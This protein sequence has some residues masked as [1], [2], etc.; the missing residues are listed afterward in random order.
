MGAE[1]VGRI[2]EE[3]LFLKGVLERR[4]AWLPKGFSAEVWDCLLALYSQFKT[5][6]EPP[7]VQAY[8]AAEALIDLQIIRLGLEPIT[9]KEGGHS[10]LHPKHGWVMFLPELEPR[11]EMYGGINDGK[12]LGSFVL[13]EEVENVLGKITSQS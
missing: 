12:L 2:H 10:Y 9:W 4:N 8:R 13:W 6:S 3:G 7:L 5:I 1:G 11:F